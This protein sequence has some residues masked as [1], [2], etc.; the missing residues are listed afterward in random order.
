MALTITVMLVTG[1]YGHSYCH[2]RH[3]A[4]RFITVSIINTMRIFSVL[5]SHWLTLTYYGCVAEVHVLYVLCFLLLAEG[6][7]M[8]VD[9]VEL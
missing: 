9:H 6:L 5:F 7:L 3:G 8:S 4:S 2:D 1:A